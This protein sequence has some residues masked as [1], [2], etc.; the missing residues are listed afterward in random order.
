MK[1]ILTEDVYKHGVAGEVV[2]VADGFARNWLIPK[3]MAIPATQTNLQK[4]SDLRSKAEQN[5]S[6]YND[7]VNAAARQIDGVELVFGVKAG[8]NN[9]LYGSITTQMIKD[10]LQKKTGLDINRR[11]ISDR[12]IR[13]L[14]RYDIPVRMGEVSPVIR[15]VVLREEEVTPYLAGKMPPAPDAE[16][17]EAAE[18]TVETPAAEAPAAEAAPAE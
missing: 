1:V 4:V 6:A 2:N 15:V 14:G 16:T 18:S 5:R 17:A 7:K 3:K 8:S 10:E 9:K 12:L 11:R 13:E